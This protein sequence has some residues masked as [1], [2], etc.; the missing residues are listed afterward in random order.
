M[1]RCPQCL[2]IYPESDTRCDFDNTALVDVDDA[3]IDFATSA[4][5]PAPPAT[6]KKKRSAGTSSKKRPSGTKKGARKKGTAITAVVGLICGVAG[7]WVYFSLGQ[8]SESVAEVPAVASVIVTP[9]VAPP[10]QQVVTDSVAE[11]ASPSPT[12]VSKTPSE[13]TAT[14]HTRTT[15]APIS[16]SGPGMGKK[17]GGRSV[18]VLATGA[19]ID[20]DEVWR[21]RDGVWYRRA[22]IVTLL[23]HNRVKAIVNQ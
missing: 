12:P 6:A 5:A 22:G 8:P 17:P 1:K 11:T 16:T 4:K 15:V 10:P 7:F 21:T 19:R 18:I 13:Q 2:F 9:L 14:S 23:K 3:E 20:A